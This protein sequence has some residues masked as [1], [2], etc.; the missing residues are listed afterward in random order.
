[1][2]PSIGRFDLAIEASNFLHSIPAGVVLGSFASERSAVVKGSLSHSRAALPS[3][4][5]VTGLVALC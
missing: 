2:K 3:G 1:M 5:I 4:M